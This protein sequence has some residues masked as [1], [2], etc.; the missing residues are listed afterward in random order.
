MRR[1][2]IWSLFCSIVDF[3]LKHRSVQFDQLFFLLVGYTLQHKLGHKFSIFLLLTI[4][5]EQ[6][7]VIGSNVQ[8]K[9]PVVATVIQQSSTS[10]DVCATAISQGP[11]VR[12]ADLYNEEE[13]NSKLITDNKK[14]K[15][16]LKLLTDYFGMQNMNGEDIL[17]VDGEELEF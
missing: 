10:L 11:S 14:C 9:I 1:N 2:Q 7:V 3:R 15:C 6:A 12:H 4:S 5:D 8:I 17:F 16:L 13:N